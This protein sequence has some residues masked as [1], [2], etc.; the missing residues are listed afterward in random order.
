MP[1]SVTMGPQGRIVIP[2]AV[3][4]RLHLEPGTALGVRVEGERIILETLDAVLH[5]LWRDHPPEP[6][7]SLVD[8]LISERR[9]EAEK[10]MNEADE[11][12]KK[13]S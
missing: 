12:R 3:R 8:E 13:Y 5:D 9:R 6:G 2:A 4:K 11:W 10:E 7:R 1:E